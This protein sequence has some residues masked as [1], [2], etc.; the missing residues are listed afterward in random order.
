MGKSSA[1]LLGMGRTQRQKLT[2]VGLGV[3]LAAAAAL[4]FSLYWRA[5]RKATEIFAAQTPE[6]ER[7]I[8]RLTSLRI[9]RPSLW[10][11]PVPEISW[12]Y[13]TQ[14]FATFASLPPSVLDWGRLRALQ[15]PTRPFEDAKGQLEQLRPVLQLLK[16]AQQAD[17]LVF[18]R[19]YLNYRLWDM[20]LSFDQGGVF[21]RCLYKLAE[22]LHSG[23]EDA[24]ALDIL[25]LLLGT[26]LDLLHGKSLMYSHYESDDQTIGACK[27]LLS[28]HSLA[29]AE[30]R[31]VASFVDRVDANRPTVRERLA[32]EDASLRMATLESEREGRDFFVW[33]QD[34]SW[35]YL[36]S[37]RLARAAAL[38]QLKKAFSDLA[39]V[40]VRPVPEWEQA[41]AG[42]ARDPSFRLI[43]VTLEDAV[44]DYAKEA[45]RRT[46]L[47]LLRTALGIALY[48]AETGR[49]PDS[50]KDLVPKYLP[51]LPR[52]D[53][54][55]DLLNFEAGRVWSRQTQK[56]PWSIER[57]P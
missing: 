31:K 16:Q 12:D 49:K 7:E 52:D 41:A 20:G 48:Q 50:L 3:L 13:Y 37:A 22:S 11:G 10:G 39:Q 51:E 27:F 30:L 25:M 28:S 14:A 34:V 29:A 19:R 21:Y 8:S 23:H 33:E 35:N 2:L 6:I 45:K 57:S 56:H 4:P 53:T 47:R 40:E 46:S 9:D 24:E 5:Q 42:I 43:A 44:R 54:S 18:H 55:G 17:R 15:E 26:S 32:A 36:W 38:I 1:E